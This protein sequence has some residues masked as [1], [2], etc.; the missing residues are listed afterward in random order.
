[1]KKNSA[2][3]SLLEFLWFAVL[4]CLI[5]YALEPPWFHSCTNLMHTC[6]PL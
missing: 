4:L 3:L 5:A 1:M 6:S 2:Q